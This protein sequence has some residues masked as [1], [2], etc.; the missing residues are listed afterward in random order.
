[1]MKKIIFLLL[2]TVLFAGCSDF[3][4]ESSQDEVI[5]TTAS[6]FS[7]LLMGSGYPLLD[8]PLHSALLLMD[9]DIAVNPYDA[10]EGRITTITARRDYYTWQPDMWAKE[11]SPFASGYEGT[12]E[13]IMGCNATLDGIDEA[14]G[15]PTLGNRTKAEAL[16][17][18]ALYYF[19]LVNTYGK[20]YN[21]DKNG[22]G[23][24]LKLSAAI[25]DDAPRNTVAEVY[26]QIEADLLDAIALLEPLEITRG[27]YRINLPAAQ[28][29]L[30]RTYLFMERWQDA[31][32]AA[33]DAIETG[34]EL[35]DFTT[36]T[37][38]FKLPDYA[39]SEVEWVYGAAREDWYVGRN[40]TNAIHA[41][42]ELRNLFAAADLRSR[43]FTL[44][45][46]LPQLNGVGKVYSYTS[47]DPTFCIR[48]A[49]AWLTRAE[50][51]ARLDELEPAQDDLDELR[52]N[53]IT[54][55]VS[56]PAAN[57]Q[58]LLD[59]ILTERRKEF[60]FEVFRWFDLRRTGMP[61]IEHRYR[62]SNTAAWELYVLE[63]DDPLYTIPIPRAAML[64][65]T[66]L[67]QNESASAPLRTSITE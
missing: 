25:V 40:N 54:G 66:K 22:L 44:G 38:A 50:A 46:S 36:K 41:S 53:R 67:V 23:V 65:N 28:I 9:D 47:K 49:E 39:N 3:L 52:Q 61:R 10:N 43:W 5:V 20:P 6:D 4:R 32:D 12:Y 17:L 31:V 64:R 8:R 26:E 33:T 58:Q 51:L 16:A 59:E 55:Y 1:M 19:E 62:N 60:C 57:K 2:C 35:T 63:Q 11:S 29:L 37:A 48:M 18:R 24:A 27:D 21:V 14:T 34:G 13:R 15:S 7:E 45:N 56:T 30:A 42:W